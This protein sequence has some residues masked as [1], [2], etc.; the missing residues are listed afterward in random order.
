MT[1]LEMLLVTAPEAL[2]YELKNTAVRVLQ[3]EVTRLKRDLE[4]CEDDLRLHKEDRLRLRTLN[5]RYEALLGD[6]ITELRVLASYVDHPD[7]EW[8]NLGLKV[9]A[10]AQKKL[11]EKITTSLNKQ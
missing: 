10:V 6:A 7:T 5:A 3:D 11:A 9:T 1:E 4:D 8:P 2:P